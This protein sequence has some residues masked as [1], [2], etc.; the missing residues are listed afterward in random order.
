MNLDIEHL[1]AWVGRTEAM[2]DG[3]TLAPRRGLTATLDRDDPPRLGEAIPPCWHWLYFL[4]MPRQ[5]AIGPDGHPRRGG[6]LPPVPLPRR[7]GAGSQIEFLAPLRAGQSISRLSRID[8]VELKEGRS[9]LP[10]FV[11]GLHEIRAEGDLALEASAT[12]A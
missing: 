10:V 3:A 4:P 7:M 11:K 2:D 5:S 6:F 9:G 1:R 12:L 8:D